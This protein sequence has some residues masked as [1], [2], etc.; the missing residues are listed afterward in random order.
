[1]SDLQLV[2]VRHG[3]TEWIERGLIH[4]RL[5]SPLSATGRLNAESAARS[6]RGGT[7]DALYSSSSGRAL[8]TAAI[9]GEVV[10]LK[11]IPVEGL[12]ETDFGWFE[13][14]AL[15]LLDAD[16]KN[17]LLKARNT[18][19]RWIM[20]VT[21]ESPEKFSARIRSA[22]DTIIENHPHG[23]VLIV[24]H[25]GVLSTLASILMEGD[26]HHRRNYGP[27][28][29]C[30]VSELHAVNGAWQAIRLNDITHLNYK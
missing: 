29:A 11:P 26:H 30:S 20:S 2:M 25:W 9:I 16:V 13:G 24:T 19:A 17:P 18:L 7:F 14:R 15:S 22:I 3:E 10:G 28:G 6:L 4:G 1:M 27:W 21:G 8:Q 5:D 23:R 12:R